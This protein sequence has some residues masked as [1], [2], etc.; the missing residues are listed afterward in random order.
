MGV[1]PFFFLSTALWD[2]IWKEGELLLSEPPSVVCITL[3][4][5]WI[6]EFLDSG[7]SKGASTPFARKGSHTRHPL[8]HHIP[9]AQT[10]PGIGGNAGVFGAD[11]VATATAEQPLQPWRLE[12]CSRTGRQENAP[13]D[14]RL[15]KIDDFSSRN[16]GRKGGHGPASRA[17]R[18]VPTQGCSG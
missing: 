5:S 15:P 12:R 10:P 3:G 8:H 1:F 7:G 9:G 17:G 4:D 11:A 6:Q 13:G 14:A 18:A 16:P 2:L